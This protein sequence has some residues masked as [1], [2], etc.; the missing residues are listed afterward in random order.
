MHLEKCIRN[1]DVALYYFDNCGEY[2]STKV[3]DK[4]I[5]M[6]ISAS[7]SVYPKHDFYR[8]KLL[9]VDFSI[10][11]VEKEI[12]KKNIDF[13]YRLD[14]MEDIIDEI[15]DKITNLVQKE[16]TFILDYNNE[17]LYNMLL[18]NVKNG[19]KYTKDDLTREILYELAI[20]ENKSDALIGDIFNL[21]KGQVRNIRIKMGLN[22]KFKIKMIDHPEG[23]MYYIEEK[24]YRDKNISNSEYMDLIGKCI[25]NRYNINPLTE[26]EVTSESDEITIN[27]DG[28][29]KLYKVTISSEP[30]SIKQPSY[31]RKN[32]G[33]HNNQK[34][35]SERKIEN[36]KLGEKIV[37][38]L[39]KKK[40]KDVGLD[41][42]I[43]EVKLIAQTDEEITFDG[44][45]YDIISYNELGERIFIEV[46]TNI[47]NKDKSFFISKKELELMKGFNSE[48][49][50]KQCFIYYVLIDNNDVKI[51][52]IDCD[53]LNDYK[54]E[55][56]LYRIVTTN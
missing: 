53:K 26:Q 17:Q 7:A 29:E 43:E 22:N 32:K 55:P 46:K 51:K 21:N 48:Y 33:S 1:I 37:E 27:V 52:K 11:N 41:Y 50:C 36:G 49:D 14:N 18:E 30:Y 23:L 35:T 47:G 42:L 13:Q 56:I 38:E 9:E 6:L 44:L 10:G 16:K 39:E 2:F 40:L 28:K 20:I 19:K 15:R 25:S 5:Y 12:S 3:R 31:S 8:K 4:I 54:L 45:G 34:K 24:G